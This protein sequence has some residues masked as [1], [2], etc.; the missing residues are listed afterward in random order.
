MPDYWR[1]GFNLHRRSAT[2]TA[3][4]AMLDLVAAAERGHMVPAA[5]GLITTSRLGQGRKNSQ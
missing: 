5:T 1:I 3:D 2:A 4:A